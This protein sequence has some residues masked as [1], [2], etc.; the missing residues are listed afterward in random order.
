MERVMSGA[1]IKFTALEACC[2]HIHV[3]IDAHVVPLS[4]KSSRSIF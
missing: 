2:A 3:H 4:N 1:G